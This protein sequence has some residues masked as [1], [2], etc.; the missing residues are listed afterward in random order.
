MKF[1]LPVSFSAILLLAADPSWKIKPVTDWTEQDAR[2]ILTDSP[3]AKTVTAS[4][5]RPMSEAARRDGGNFGQPQGVGYDGISTIG[6][7]LDEILFGGPGPPEQTMPVQLRWESA[8][9][10][11][12]AEQRAGLPKPPEF[13]DEG[14]IVAV[15]GVPRVR[16]PKGTPQ[17]LGAPLKSSAFLHR[18]GKRDVKPSD[19]QVFQREDGLVILYL[20]P[21]FAEITRKDGLVLF[22]AR[23]GR[24]GVIQYFDTEEMQ[25][26]GK[27]EL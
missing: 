2:Q 3:W 24:I 16:N 14:Y 5:S 13:P 23:I 17:K 27:M 1:L 20:F 10:V 19:V 11:R 9:P 25:F 21:L 18:D 8:F 22:S 12:A 26:Q 4:I 6:L 15:Y 7:T